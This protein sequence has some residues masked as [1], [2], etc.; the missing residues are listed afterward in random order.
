MTYRFDKPRI[1]MSS[2]L[3]ALLFVALLV[4]AC[5]TIACAG[6]SG[7]SHTAMSGM[8][9]ADCLG[10]DVAHTALLAVQSSAP[11]WLMTFALLGLAMVQFIAPPSRVG[12]SFARIDTGP[13]PPIEPRGER[14]LV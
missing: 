14:F 5:M 10:T 9:M 12:W 4:P 7:F 8:S 13:P 6:D 1:T 2:L 11:T 3:A